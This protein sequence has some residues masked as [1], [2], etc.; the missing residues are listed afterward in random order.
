MSD[1]NSMLF[2]FFLVFLILTTIFVTSSIA[3]AG[4][5]DDNTFNTLSTGKIMIGFPITQLISY[6]ESINQTEGIASNV[7]VNNTNQTEGIASNVKVNNTNQPE[8]IAS[9]VKVNNTN[10]P[11]GIA[12]NVKVNNTNQPD[13]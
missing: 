11:E 8:G 2:T 6:T 7:K 1:K 4:I 10:Q 3:F 5:I 9:N 13:Q 12:S